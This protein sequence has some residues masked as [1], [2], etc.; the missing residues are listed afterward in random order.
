[1]LS[2]TVSGRVGAKFGSSGPVHSALFM[3]MSLLLADWLKPPKPEISCFVAK[4][5]NGYLADSPALAEH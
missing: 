2:L 5:A 3:S 1:V 4:S